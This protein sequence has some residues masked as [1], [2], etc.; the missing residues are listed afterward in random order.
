MRALVTGGAG[1]IGSHL[2][3]ELLKQNYEVVS[4]DNLE[5]RIHAAGKPGY[6]PSGVRF[7]QGD[8]RDKSVWKGALEGVDIVFH[9]AAY[10]DY[11][12][13][14]SKFFHTNVVGTVLLYEVIRDQKLN[15]QKIVVASSQAVYGEGQYNCR[16][17]GM[18]L[19]P[20]RA[21]AQMERGDWEVKCP[22]CGAPV[23]YQQLR[24][25][26]PNPYNQYALSKYSQEL[27]ALRLGKLF[28]IPT[29]ALRYSITQGARQSP[30]NTY[31]GICRIFTLRFLNNQ[32]P[33]IYEDGKQLRDYVHVSD[34]V[35]ANLLVARDPRADF[36]P[37]N[38]GSGKGVTVFEY[39]NLL[40]RILGSD[41]EPIVPGKY[42]VGDNRN[43][44]SSI[45][46]LKVLGWK[47]KKSLESIMRDYVEW[48]ESTGLK[49]QYYLRADHEME[50]AGVVRAATQAV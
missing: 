24:E 38:V 25:E 42:R 13:D 49:D 46:K 40:A 29:V 50:S 47:P 12:P 15:V 37:F 26:Y 20:A 35:E 7:V 44:V 17:D 18:V 19:P 39:A 1:F 6:L 33:V 28:G 41:L 21:Q 14:Y 5:P 8:V 34:V 45:E 43:S 36:E 2:V 27:A 10:Q 23:Q 22:K 4:L 30:H 48:L 9:Q 11:M 3:E 32:P 16:I 31:S